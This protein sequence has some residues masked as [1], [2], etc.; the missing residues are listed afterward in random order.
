MPL[1]PQKFTAQYVQLLCHH[2]TIYRLVSGLLG[3]GWKGSLLTSGLPSLG[4]NWSWAS[5]SPPMSPNLSWAEPLRHFAWSSVH[6]LMVKCTVGSSSVH[7]VMVWCT[8]GVSLSATLQK[9]YSRCCSFAKRNHFLYDFVVAHLL[10][11]LL[12]TDD[13]ALLPPA[14]GPTLGASFVV[15]G[16]MLPLFMHW[17]YGSGQ[18]QK[19]RFDV[20]WNIYLLDLGMAL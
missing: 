16:F 17:A 19:H 1:A 5:A 18:R 14:I 2:R 20:E 12:L 13:V 9:S 11:D 10:A 6:F 3:Q 15:A 4:E 8:A 7:L